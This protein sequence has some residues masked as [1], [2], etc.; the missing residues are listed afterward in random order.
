M[1]KFE[2]LKIIRD[3]GATL[4]GD[5]FPVHY[6]RGY[7][8][9]RR[10]CYV[11]DVSN[12]GRILRAVNRLLRRSKAGDFVGVWIDGGRAYI[13]ISERVE[14][15]GDAIRV[16]LER[17]QKSIYDWCCDRCITLEA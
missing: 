10:D 4:N 8:V 1:K 14:R 17:K 3:G 15:L 7:Q 9:S 13:D 11:L 16:G 12:V 2:L 5:G 6:S